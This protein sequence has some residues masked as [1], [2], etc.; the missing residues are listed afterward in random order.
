[1]RRRREKPINDFVF[2]QH[3]VKTKVS[4]MVDAKTDHLDLDVA[5][6]IREE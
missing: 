2:G 3:Q 1:M 4:L 5:S 6:F